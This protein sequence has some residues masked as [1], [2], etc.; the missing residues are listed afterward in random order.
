MPLLGSSAYN[1]AG[2]VTSLIRSLVND[3]SGNWATDA[4]LL[5]YVSSVYRTT[6]KKIAN[7][8][9][10]GFIQDDTLLVVKAVP[11]AQQDPGT[12]TVINDATPAPNQLPSNLL[13]P[14]KIWERPNLSTQQFVEMEDMSQH[15]GLP[16]RIQTATLG[17]WEWRSD[18]IYFV[19]ATQDVQ[20]RLRFS[21]A[22][23][24]L[25]GSGDVI[26]I[27]GA[28]ECLAYG[29]AGLVGLARGSPVAEKID[30]LYSDAIEDVILENV[31]R[32]QNTGR[33]RKPFRSRMRNWGRRGF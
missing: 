18:G 14:L 8:G 25:A 24:D 31:R 1:T 23:P 32:D 13:V 22:F 30:E 21:A 6:Q 33:R 7:A 16:S 28:I 19:G 5:P 26:L 2:Q 9:G 10:E 11:A 3:A 15:G 27:R 29:A 4:V 12:Q 20:I 17:E